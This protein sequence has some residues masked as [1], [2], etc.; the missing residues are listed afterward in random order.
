MGNGIKM[1]LICNDLQTINAIPF[2][3]IEGH[4]SL[5]C[6]CYSA[7][8]GLQPILQRSRIGESTSTIDIN[9]SFRDR[10]NHLLTTTLPSQLNFPS[11]SACLLEGHTNRN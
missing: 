3:N 9:S 4:T 10:L 11:Q 2:C 5:N 1:T 6:Q 8:F 7:E